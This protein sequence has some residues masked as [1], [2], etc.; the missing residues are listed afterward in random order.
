MLKIPVAGDTPP[1]LM[2]TLRRADFEDD[3][4]AEPQRRVKKRRRGK[5]ANA[6][7]NPSWERDHRGSRSGRSD[8]RQ[9][10]FLL[11]S[12]VVLL[13]LVGGG[14]YVAMNRDSGPPPVVEGPP[15]EAATPTAAVESA[16]AGP[17]GDA[18]LLAE[19]EP[20]VT[21]FL[22]AK[23]VDELLPLVRHPEITGPR[24]QAFYPDGK[25]HAPGLSKF[26]SGSGIFVRGNLVSI[27]LITG[28]LENR[29]I[30]L[31]DGSEG[32]KIDWESWA[33]WSDISL[34]EF[35]ATKPTTS[36]VFRVTVSAVDYYNFGFSDESEWK[37]YRLISPDGADS[38]YG[39]VPKES[40]LDVRLQP[41]PDSKGVAWMLALKY[42]ADATSGSQVE[43]ERIVTEGWV[44]TD[45]AP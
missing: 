43:I 16:P 1:P 13:A 25:I 44:E 28:E 22:A 6:L 10:R 35:M 23:S 38:L 45:E 14:A 8:N 7:A 41:P 21:Q 34:D 5:S 19:A 9:M 30:A 33:R 27:P 36:H 40:V 32:L 37:S 3:E 31:I 12:G 26:N 29:A 39:Y 42:P 11:I 17:R 20:L 4:V 24:M 15:T 18:T 2:A